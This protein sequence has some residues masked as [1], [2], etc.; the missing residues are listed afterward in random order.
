M[1]TCN[2]VALRKQI[3][4]DF[5]DM[6]LLQRV[7]MLWLLLGESGDSSEHLNLNLLLELAGHTTGEQTRSNFSTRVDASQHVG[8][9][10]G[11]PRVTRIQ[12]RLQLSLRHHKSEQ[13][14]PRLD[15]CKWIRILL[16]S[17]PHRE[18]DLV[19]QVL[20]DVPHLRK[21][22][23]KIAPDKGRKVLQCNMCLVRV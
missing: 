23:M 15:P 20:H 11:L 3:A 16:C 13:M 12:H 18:K 4:A 7:V 8:L 10:I 19:C 6:L 2:A 9:T 5:V 14:S 1:K 21:S 17:L 22:Q